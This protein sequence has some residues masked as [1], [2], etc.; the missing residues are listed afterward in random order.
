MAKETHG[1]G[2]T[3]TETKSSVTTTTPGPAPAPGTPAIAL[4]GALNRYEGKPSDPAVERAER[5]YLRS[6]CGKYP[7]DENALRKAMRA[8]SKQGDIK[9][10]AEHAGKLAALITSR[11]Q[12]TRVESVQ[13]GAGDAH[14]RGD[15]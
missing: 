9:G 4:C 13:T 15:G 3:T 2:A 7:P 5:R 6:T 10:A 14:K 11:Q 1:G 12:E 8:A